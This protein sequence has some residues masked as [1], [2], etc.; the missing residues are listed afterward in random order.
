MGCFHL[1]VLLFDPVSDFKFFVEFLT[2][3]KFQSGLVFLIGLG[4]TVR[5][6]LPL[7]YF[8]LIPQRTTLTLLLAKRECVMCIPGISDFFV[9]IHGQ[10]TGRAL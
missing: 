7:F 6:L 2:V 8:A 1:T 4:K 3:L 9:N 5:V 10:M